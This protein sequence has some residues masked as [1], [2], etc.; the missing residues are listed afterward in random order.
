MGHQRGY[1][2][3]L[4]VVGKRP[5]FAKHFEPN[6]VGIDEIKYVIIHHKY[7]ILVGSGISQQQSPHHSLQVQLHNRSSSNQV[8]EK[9]SGCRIHGACMLLP[10]INDIFIYNAQLQLYYALFT[11]GFTSCITSTISCWCPHLYIHVS[12]QTP[13]FWAPDVPISGLLES[14][15]CNMRSGSSTS[16]FGETSAKLD[17]WDQRIVVAY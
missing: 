4:L 7:D 13:T 3:G 8:T 14:T 2:F 12:C 16:V 1:E 10:K 6:L 15:R 17:M 11:I 9:A 5:M